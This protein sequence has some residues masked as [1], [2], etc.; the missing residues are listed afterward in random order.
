M[1]LKNLLGRKTRSLLTVF[2]IAVGVAAIVALGALREGFA[3][4]YSA[5]GGGSGADVLVMQDD[6]L[7]IA[8]SAVDEDA[9]RYINDMPGV[10][11]AEGFLT[12]YT[13][14]GDLPFFI[15]Y[16]YAPRGL[17]IR[18]FGIVERTPLTTN[19]QILLGRVAANNLNKS[20]G[21][22]LR[23]FDSTFKIV[24]IHE[25]GVP[26]QD[27]GG[28]MTLRDAQRLF[29]Q[30]RKVSFIGLWLEDKQQAE[31]ITAAVEDRLPEIDLAQSIEFAE[32]L[33][34]MQM[35]EAGTWAISAMALVGGGLG[36]TNTMVM[37]VFECTREIGVLRA[38]GWR[39]RR[40]PQMIVRESVV[41]SLLGGIAGV[42]T[43][44][45]LGMILNQLPVIQGVLRL[46]Y[47]AGLF[48]QAVGTAVVLGVVGGIYPAWQATRL[49]PVEALRY[50]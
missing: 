2:G 13:T 44:V 39:R 8:L 14:L 19:R 31:A 20:I 48:I 6:A 50:E 41:L 33:M 38:L 15:V 35:M 18:E 28:V 11:T 4:G 23:V 10:A 16:G 25:T 34:D 32:G 1:I 7:D 29:G 46:E 9:V 3:D 30:P 47:R 21:Q 49:R 37:S 22:S 5:I 27:G 12:G 26:F 36:M 24:G 42:V 45:L 40:I 17:A 43:G